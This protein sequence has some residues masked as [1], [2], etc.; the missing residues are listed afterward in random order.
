MCERRI[1][2]Y[3][4][5]PSRPPGN[6]MC[7]HRRHVYTAFSM[8]DLCAAQP[9][10]IFQKNLS[11]SCSKAQISGQAIFACRITMSGLKIILEQTN[12]GYVLTSSGFVCNQAK[13]MATAAELGFSDD[14]FVEDNQTKRPVNQ[15][16]LQRSL[17]AAL[18]TP[19]AQSLCSPYVSCIRRTGGGL[20]VFR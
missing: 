15:P 1:C 9:R 7:W 12:P 5:G 2:K 19:P 6:N 11:L 3:E 13:A 8:I 10:H 4:V 16:H 20:P 17:P 14:Y 18:V